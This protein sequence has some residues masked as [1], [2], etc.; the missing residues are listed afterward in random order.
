MIKIKRYSEVNEE[1]IGAALKGALGKVFN[2]FAQPFKDLVNDIKKTYKEGDP[3]SVKNLLITKLNQAIDACQKGL[4]DKAVDLPAVQGMMSQFVAK[5]GELA[6]GMTSDFEKALGK[7]KSNAPASIAK[8]LLT[9]DK[10]AGWLGIIGMLNQIDYKY[11]KINY[12]KSLTDA[13]K[14]KTGK[15]ALAAAKGAATKF[16]DGFQKDFVGRIQKDF[17]DDEI[18]KL[19]DQ[20]SKTN[21]KGGNTEFKEGDTVRY[22]TNEYDEGQPEDGQKQNIA[23]GQVK[24]IEGTKVTIFNP[25]INQDVIKTKDKVLGKE[26]AVEEGPNAKQAHEIL[27]KLKGDDKKMGQVVK[28]AQFIS[29]DAN[30]AKV[31]DIEKIINQ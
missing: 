3:N 11:S 2:L 10:E 6:N 26:A 17:T 18:K 28:F 31:P 22:K 7:D 24:K 20:V 5:L 15:D 27:G 13:S 19:Y 16:F 23:T 9:G 30:Q 8:A 21:A 25:K 29:N 1:F 4:N 14:G 12:D